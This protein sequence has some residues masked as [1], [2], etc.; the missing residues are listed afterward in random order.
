LS[1]ASLGILGILSGFSA[2]GGFGPRLF[3]TFGAMPKVK[4]FP[5]IPGLSDMRKAKEPHQR[6]F[7]FDG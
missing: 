5:C 3:V 2:F 7:L 4:P 1:V 6:F